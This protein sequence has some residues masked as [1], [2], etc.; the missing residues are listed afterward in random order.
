MGVDIRHVQISVR[1]GVGVLGLWP[2][3]GGRRCLSSGGTCWAHLQICSRKSNTTKKGH[4]PTAFAADVS[5]KEDD[6]GHEISHKKY[7]G[8]GT[9]VKVLFDF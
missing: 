3:F 8:Q 9:E 7:R 4:L 2:F 5:S 6:T 1:P